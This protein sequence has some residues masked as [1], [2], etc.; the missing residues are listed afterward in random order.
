MLYLKNRDRYRHAVGTKVFIMAN[1][2]FNFNTCMGLKINAFRVRKEKPL[3]S[4]AILENGGH[5]VFFLRG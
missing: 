2:I 3:S 1:F 5:I 4:A